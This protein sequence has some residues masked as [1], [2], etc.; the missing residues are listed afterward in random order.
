MPTR[1]INKLQVRCIASYSMSGVCSE[2]PTPEHVSGFQF[3]VS[4][5]EV[6]AQTFDSMHFARLYV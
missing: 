2:A 4:Q 5:L 1:A 3:R 6:Q